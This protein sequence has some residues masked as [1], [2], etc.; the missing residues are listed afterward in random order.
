MTGKPLHEVVK[1]GGCCSRAAPSGFE[2]WD[3]LIRNRTRRDAPP[4]CRHLDEAGVC[5]VD[6]ASAAAAAA[7]A[8]GDLN[9]GW[10]SE[11]PFGCL[12]NRVNGAHVEKLVASLTDHLV[13]EVCPATRQ[14]PICVCKHGL[15]RGDIPLGGGDRAVRPHATLATTKVG[16]GSH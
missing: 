1:V 5:C 3:G 16:L 10:S 7:A 11:P 12:Q 14:G 9:A 6:V 15:G 2:G 4:S 13:A 8:A